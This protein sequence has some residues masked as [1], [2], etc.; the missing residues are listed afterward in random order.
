M[1]MKKLMICVYFGDLPSW[2]DRYE[3]PMGYDFLLENDL[4]S[5][6]E[7]VQRILGFEYPA[8]YGDTKPWDYRGAL[9]LLYAEELKNYDFWAHTDLDCV[10]GQTEKWFSDEELNQLD[11]WSN[12]GTYVCGCWC[13]YRNT[14]EV[15]EL[16]MQYP[17]W[18][19]KMMYAESNG[20]VEQEYS[21]LVE[22]SG[23]RYRYSFHQGD[24]YTTEPKLKKE[25]D[26]L[27]QEINGVW[28][29]VMMF[30]FRRSKKWPL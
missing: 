15:N 9:G 11:I 25:G 2:M 5:F 8:G 19:Q 27:F 22:Q 24:P 17:Y 29:E 1:S 13:L 21:R 10:Y 28:E 18:K 26:A 4:E 7:R 6:K 16:F 23:L 20:W 14:K 30:H 12:H 3:P